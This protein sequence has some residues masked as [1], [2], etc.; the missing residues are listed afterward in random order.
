[1][2]TFTDAGGVPRREEYFRRIGGIL[3]EES[4]R[5]S[6]AIYA[7]GLPEDW[8]ARLSKGEWLRC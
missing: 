2:S 5:G 7:Q 1:M 3:G 8:A 4:C 6:F